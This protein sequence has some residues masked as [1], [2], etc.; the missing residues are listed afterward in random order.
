MVLNKPKQAMDHLLRFATIE[1]Q[2]KH[3]DPDLIPIF[4][5]IHS[6]KNIDSF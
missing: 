1:T 2:S 3:F 5:L 6:D 4:P